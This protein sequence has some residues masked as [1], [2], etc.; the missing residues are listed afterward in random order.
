MKIV[1][2]NLYATNSRPKQKQKRLLQRKKKART[3]RT[4][5]VT[6]KLSATN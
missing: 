3:R 6:D 2:E 1:T 4:K 5:L